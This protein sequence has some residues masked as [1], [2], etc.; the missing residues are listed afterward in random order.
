MVRKDPI[1][2]RGPAP[3]NGRTSRPAA[4]S[5]PRTLFQLRPVEEYRHL[6]ESAISGVE[7][8]MKLVSLYTSLNMPVD[9]LEGL[10]RL[11]TIIEALIK[12]QKARK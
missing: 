6:W 12:Q 5:K 8:Q 4:K 10:E 1:N 3:P 11:Q 9:Y 2:E 7:E